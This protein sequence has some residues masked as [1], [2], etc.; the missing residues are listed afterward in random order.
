[1]AS[2]QKDP[3]LGSTFRL[4]ARRILQTTYDAGLQDPQLLSALADLSQATNPPLAGQLARRALESDAEL[5]ALDRANSLGILG[6]SLIAAGKL[7]EAIP[8]LQRLVTIH[9]NPVAWLQLSQ[10]QMSTGDTPGAIA[11]AEQAVKIGAH[12][13]EVHDLLSRLYQQAG[14]APKARRHR[15]I[16]ESLARAGQGGR[17]R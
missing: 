10:C 13:A 1:L 17:S 12:R 4:R 5:T 9:H 11:A 2:K 14:Q 6:N 15:Q 3:R 7:D 16:A 8:V